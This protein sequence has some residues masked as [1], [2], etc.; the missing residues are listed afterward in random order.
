[1]SKWMFLQHENKKNKRG[2]EQ[3]ER[4]ICNEKIVKIYLISTSHSAFGLRAAD[5][6][7]PLTT[8]E[9]ILI[10]ICCLSRS[11]CANEGDFWIH[12]WSDVENPTEVFLLP[13]IFSWQNWKLTLNRLPNRRQKLANEEIC[14]VSSSSAFA[15]EKPVTWTEEWERPTCTHRFRKYNRSPLNLHMKKLRMKMISD[16]RFIFFSP[17]PTTAH[18]ARPGG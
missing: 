1:M 3:L 9:N 7:D 2:K 8:V 12:F 16:F 17:T 15:Y 14:S 13:F 6:Y 11:M 5:H 10:L 18:T 4:E